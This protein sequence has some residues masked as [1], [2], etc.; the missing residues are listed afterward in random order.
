MGWNVGLS[1]R[2]VWIVYVDGPSEA[3]SSLRKGLSGTFGYI[4]PFRLFSGASGG[5]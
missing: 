2:A 3:R 4:A 5:F 1:C